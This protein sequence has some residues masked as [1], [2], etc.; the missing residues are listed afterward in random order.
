MLTVAMRV[1][2]DLRRNVQATQTQQLT[3]ALAAQ[4]KFTGPS[5]ELLELRR[6]YQ[7]ALL[8]ALRSALSELS[9]EENNILRLYYFEGLKMRQ[10]AHV[11]RVNP[12]TI[13]RWL[14]NAKLQ[15]GRKI[16]E[17][18]RQH[19]VPLPSGELQS[20]IRALLSQLDVHDVVD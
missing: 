6:C 15:L 11:F 10:I 3:D 14:D 20:L 18:L 2:H 1:A 5:V 16:K 12:S 17:Q 8:Q 7:P 13:K 9:A 4:I 19:I